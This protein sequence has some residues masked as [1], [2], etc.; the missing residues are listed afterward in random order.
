[1]MRLADSLQLAPAMGVHAKICGLRSPVALGV[2][3][4][5]A[6]DS[7]AHPRGK[8]VAMASERKSQMRAIR[9]GEESV[10]ICVVECTQL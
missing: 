3:G 4:N 7:L 6:V 10:P 8:L 9:E 1:M 5:I 2:A